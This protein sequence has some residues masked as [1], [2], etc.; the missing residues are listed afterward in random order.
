[1]RLT[2]PLGSAMKSI[3]VAVSLLG[4]PCIPACAIPIPPPSTDTQSTDTAGEPIDTSTTHS[5]PPAD[6]STSR[7][8]STSTSDTSAAAD[9]TTTDSGTTSGAR[10][11][12]GT[13]E[14]DE[15]C[16]GTDWNGATCEGLGYA[17]GRLTCTERCSLEVTGCTPEGM[18]LVLEGTFEMGSDSAASEQPIR[19]VW[20]DDFYIDA[21]E[22]TVAEYTACVGVGVCAPP[23]TPTKNAPFCNWTIPGRQDHP[24]N[25]I[26]WFDA[27][28]YCGWAD[29][30]TKRLPTE[31]EWEK[32]A[33]SADA[34]TY[35]W[36]NVPAPSC[37]RAIMHDERDGGAG[38]GANSTAIV[39]SRPRGSSPMGAQDMAGN[40]WEW[41]ADRF[42]EYDPQRLDNPTGPTS[43]NARVLRGGGWDAVS[44]ASVRTTYRIGIGPSDEAVE[45]LGNVG[46]RCA[47]T[48]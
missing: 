43:G 40:V 15:Q 12:N 17:P 26:N 14:R 44:A 30:G 34:R 10:C 9:S 47:R 20:V 25:C 32:A 48:P 33:R 27:Q 42:A 8:G 6:S 31:A 1:M 5:D 41:V 22:V 38:C 16:D 45:Q 13:V 19:Q 29:G 2:L 37:A 7:S 39:G 46:F 4:M 18:V 35:P 28:E 24:V 21:T 11:G 36:G 3:V 23:A